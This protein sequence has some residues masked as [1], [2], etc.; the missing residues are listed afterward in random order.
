M[1]ADTLRTT[2]ADCLRLR[3][4]T[5]RHDQVLNSFLKALLHAGLMD[6]DSNSSG[7]SGSSSNNNMDKIADLIKTGAYTWPKD[8]SSTSTATPATPVTAADDSGEISI[9]PTPHSASTPPPPIPSPVSVLQ[10]M[11][12]L[13]D[14]VRL[15]KH[16]I[17]NL[18]GKGSRYLHSGVYKC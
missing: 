11:A 10:V 13:T 5:E 14:R 1:T 16:T 18:L 12:V 2:A 17:E 6:S 9:I 8:T 3:H 15:Y 7:N 4:R